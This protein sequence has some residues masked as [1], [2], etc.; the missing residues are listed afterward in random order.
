MGNKETLMNAPVICLMGPTASGKTDIAINLSEEFPIDIISVDSALVYRDMNIGTAKPDDKML[1]LYPHALVNIRDPE[2]TYSVGD[3]VNDVEKKIRHSHEKKR[4][5][6]LVGG[7]MMYFRSLMQGIAKLPEANQSLRMI[8]NEE[9]N[10]IGWP[11]MHAKLSD[12]DPFSAKRINKNDSQ[13]IQRAIEVF[14]LTGKPLSDLQKTSE[15]NSRF[16]YLKFALIPRPR[17]VLHEIIE[18]RLQKMLEKGF[19]QEVEQLKSREKLTSLH[20]SMRAV[21]YKQIWSHLEGDLEVSELFDQI[22][23]ATRQLAKRQ[24]TWI[25][26]EQK[27]KVLNP[28]EVDPFDIISAELNSCFKIV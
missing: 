20:A 2:D 25:R 4:I 24:I 28:L 5:P 18:K 17:K 16:S 21:G 10:Q 26:K 27:I 7:T 23:F 14:R 15:P 12:V 8:I 11:A 9:A 3:F 13:R 22:L 19:I 6:F 1:K